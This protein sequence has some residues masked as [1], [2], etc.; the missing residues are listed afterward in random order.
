MGVNIW[1]C[2]SAESMGNCAVRRKEISLPRD[3]PKSDEGGFLEWLAL[4][5]EADMD[6]YFLLKVGLLPQEDDW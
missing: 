1:E 3:D 5:S 6:G 2:N 4:F